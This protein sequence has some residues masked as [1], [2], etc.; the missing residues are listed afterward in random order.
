MTALRAVRESQRSR[1]IDEIFMKPFEK[2]STVKLTDR[3]AITLSKARGNP[4]WVGRLGT[5]I[6]CNRFSVSIL[7]EGR[8]SVDHV[9]NKAVELALHRG[10]ESR[11]TA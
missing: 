7:W 2:G 4:N 8:M 1:H 9:P 6:C 5:V 11:T 10:S 3:Y